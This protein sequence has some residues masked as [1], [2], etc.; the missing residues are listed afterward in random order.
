MV[1]RHRNKETLPPNDFSST[2]DTMMNKIKRLLLHR[3][4][5]G[6]LED[7]Q[8]Q[9]PNQYPAV[10]R[11]APCNY[12]TDERAE[13]LL[14]EFS[15]DEKLRFISGQDNFSV[16]A[17]PRLGLPQVWMSDAS[18]GVRGHGPA[19][20]FPAA[21]AM[22]ATWNRA[23][24]HR[25]AK[26][27]AEEC[28][29]KGISVLL[30]PGI[31][32]ARVPTCG[33]NF[34]YMGEDPYVAGEM[35]T[36]YIRGVQSMGVAATV[37][38]YVANNSDYD[39]H[40]ESSDIDETTL[41]ELYLPAF[42]KAVVMADTKA[43]M[44]A[45]NPVNGTWMSENRRLIREILKGEWNFKGAV[46][47]DWISVYSTA[48]AVQAGLDIEMPSAKWFTIKK[49]KKELYRGGI[50]I[51]DIDGKVRTLLKMG[52]EIGAY[53]RPAIEQGDNNSTAKDNI[54]NLLER[55]S[56]IAQRAAEEAVVLLKNESFLPLNRNTTQTI[57]VLGRTS[58]HT[59]TGGGGSSYVKT[60]STV[61]ILEGI[62]EACGD[63]C[64]IEHIETA[65]PPFS[66]LDKRKI[67]Q[68]D[69]VICATGFDHELESE[70]Y[71]R[72]WKL[73]DHEQELIMAA[74]ELNPN[75]AVVLTA[76]GDLCTDIWADSV[77]AILHSFYLGQ[78]AGNVVAS[79]IFGSINPSGRLPFTMSRRWND[80]AAV[81]NYHSIP[82]KI[83][84]LRFF[85]PQGVRGIRAK[86]SIAYKEGLAVGYRNFDMYDIEPRFP[87]GHGLSYTQFSYESI[88]ISEPG[89]PIHQFSHAPDGAM[90]AVEVVLTN[91]GSRAG[92]EVIQVYL[93]YPVPPTGFPDRPRPPKA[94]RGFE[95]IHLHPGES[96]RVKVPIDNRAFF[97]FNENDGEWHLIPGS[98]T[99]MCGSSSRDIRLTETIELDSSGVS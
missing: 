68:S 48:K 25:A 10:A 65:K 47:S 22:A 83:S 93:S 9:V 49:L 52:F 96:R 53:D 92:S 87:F 94:L 91:T 89:I 36:A 58:T 62:R 81:R 56:S 27:I 63:A 59:D 42:R 90:Q 71:D 54:D 21:V 98:Y 1:K 7:E 30:A 39:R 70:F 86:K 75:I 82:E 33:R 85:G 32:I 26:C 57:A 6:I 73:P 43:L 67:K 29:A 61:S 99:I 19:T 44:T 5:R 88:E 78:N 69:A 55:N 18:S 11:R 17:I 66:E 79:I 76:G 60:E 64:R 84:L 14:A 38:H 16:P 31:N 74:Q 4:T 72:S 28:R 40:R 34:E 37:K 80:I 77:K 8:L 50:S 95:K 3:I 2:I 51:K 46:I 97:L 23:L 45:Y 35:A 20:S 24:V 41:R 13:R 12:T 15:V